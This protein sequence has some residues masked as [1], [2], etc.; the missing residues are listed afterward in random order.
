MFRVVNLVF[1]KPVY[2]KIK[3]W[4]MIGRGTRYALTY[5]GRATI[6]RTFGYSISASTL[7]SSERTQTA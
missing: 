7:I 2:S 3:F 5:S 1:F 4:Q 6:K